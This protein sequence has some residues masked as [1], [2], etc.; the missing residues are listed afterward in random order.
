MSVL[1]ENLNFSKDG[2]L[3]LVAR[4]S[5][6]SFLP[7]STFPLSKALVLLHVLYKQNRNKLDLVASKAQPGALLQ[8]RQLWVSFRQSWVIYRFSQGPRSEGSRCWCWLGGR[9]PYKKAKR[10][11][12]NTTRISIQVL[13]RFRKPHRP[14]TGNRSSLP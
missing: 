6:H 1:K 10:S 14:E 13:T 11:S 9:G 2:I 5:E 8:R 4:V 12:L 3:K 7:P